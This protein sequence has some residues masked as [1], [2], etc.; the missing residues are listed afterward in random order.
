MT[1]SNLRSDSCTISKWETPRL[2]DE[3]S[4]EKEQPENEE[5]LRNQAY[6]EARK[7]GY[8]DGI[9]Q[10]IHE[11]DEKLLAMNTFINALSK[12]FNDQNQQLA[13]YISILAGKIAK[14]LVRRELRTEPETI[15][16]LVRD[17]VSA[18]NSSEPDIKVHLN[19]DNAN[20][21]RKIINTDSQEQNW[22]IVDDPLVSHSDCKVSHLDSL[23]DADLQAR[24]NIIITQFLGDARSENRK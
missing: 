3:Q 1:R 19:P 18:L 2:V 21:I 24:I 4:A 12:P 9:D 15:M 7:L 16:A 13:E 23:I 14:A 10:S 5:S 6:E 20:I 8:Q 11:L 22:S 17:T